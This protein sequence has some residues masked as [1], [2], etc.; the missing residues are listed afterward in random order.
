MRGILFHPTGTIEFVIFK[1]IPMMTR[2][3]ITAIG[4]CTIVVTSSIVLFTFINICEYAK[5]IS[6]CVILNTP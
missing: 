3:L 2:A 4:I 5:V 1:S 6:M